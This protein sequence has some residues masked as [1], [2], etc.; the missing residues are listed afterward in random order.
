M[1]ILG[2]PGPWQ[3]YLKRNLGKPTNQIRQQ[4]LAEQLMYFRAQDQ[5][6]NAFMVQGASQAQVASVPPVPLALRLLFSDIAA[7]NAIVGDSSNVSDWNTY[8]DLP[9]YGT[10]FTSVSVTGDEVKLY[11]G[12]GIKVKP[13]LL[14]NEQ[15]LLIELDDQAGCIT[16]VGG[17]AFSYNY[18]LTTVNLPECTVVYGPEDSPQNDVGGF[19]YC[20]HLVSLSIPKLV[21]V[22]NYGF[23]SCQLLSSI[24]FPLLASIGNYGFSA[25]G[26]LALVN[27]PNVVSCGNGCFQS[28]IITS[29]SLPLAT[30]IGNN[31]F[32]NCDG[33]TNIALLGCTSLGTTV[34]N[35]SVFSNITGNIITLTVP[36]A[37]MTNNGGNPDGDIQYL[38][39]N[40]TV[41]VVTV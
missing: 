31:C 4:Y 40:N 25:C 10:P 17:D 20:D 3:D 21:T 18:S 30:N 32:S 2:D 38:Q 1:N 19:G 23:D 6:M 11:G 39:A 35:N 12:S 9:T 5:M 16:S 7:V 37:L 27:V 34:G 14:Y 8:F 13:A 33:L 15:N 26:N 41:T 24:N 29:I 28:S 22:G 36:S